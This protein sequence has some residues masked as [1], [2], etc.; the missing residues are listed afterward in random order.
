MFSSDLSA[1]PLNI[2]NID[3]AYLPTGLL[4]LIQNFVFYITQD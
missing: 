4:L 2:E 3:N 1:L